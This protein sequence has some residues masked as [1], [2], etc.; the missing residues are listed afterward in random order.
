MNLISGSL[1]LQLLHEFGLRFEL[2][3]ILDVVPLQQ[4]GPSTVC[5]WEKPFFKWVIFQHTTDLSE[6]DGENTSPIQ[7]LACH[8]N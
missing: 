2:F 6:L 1:D 8:I 3:N 4:S 7:M 5:S